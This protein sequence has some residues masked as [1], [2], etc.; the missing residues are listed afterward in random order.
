MFALYESFSQMRQS[1]SYP[2]MLLLLV[3]S[4]HQM[5]KYL[6]SNTRFSCGSHLKRSLR[7]NVGSTSFASTALCSA[8]VVIAFVCGDTNAIRR[9]T[10]KTQTGKVGV[11]YLLTVV[12][13]FY[14]QQKCTARFPIQLRI[15]GLIIL[16]PRGHANN[17]QRST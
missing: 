7:C 16:C 5:H 3:E 4:S 8:G 9:T 11:V 12:D 13:A 1:Y 14:T 15:S 17:S 10:D 6:F 2:M